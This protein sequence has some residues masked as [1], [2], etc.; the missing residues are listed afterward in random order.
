V[1]NNPVNLVDPTGYCGEE[2]EVTETDEGYIII[3]HP[4]CTLDVWGNLIRDFL[5][6]S[7]NPNCYYGGCAGYGGGGG[8]GFGEAAS[9]AGDIGLGIHDIVE[10][11]HNIAH[12]AV[13]I[14]RLDSLGYPFGFP[15]FLSDPCFMATGEVCGMQ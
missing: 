9:E 14:S 10:M 2:D 15:K 12:V 7:L 4:P 11:A 1:L 5:K 3:S 8:A 13:V 6:D